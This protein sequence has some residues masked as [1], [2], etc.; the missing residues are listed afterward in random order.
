MT[1]DVLFFRAAFLRHTPQ[2]HALML[3]PAEARRLDQK[4]DERRGVITD[5]MI[6]HHLAGEIA[7]AAPAAVD[8]RASLLPL[9]IDAGGLTAIH[10]LL[11]E[12][13]KRDLWA[14]GQYCPRPGLADEDQRGYVWLP[15][16]QAIDTE[17]LQDLGAALIAA[18]SQP[19]WKIEAR[20]T[21][22]VTRLP[23]ARHTHTG[24]FGDLVMANQLISIDQD[25]AGALDELCRAYRENPS[26][27]LPTLSAPHQPAPHPAVAQ[28]N[29][30]GITITRYNQVHNI[31]DVIQDYGARP[32]KRRG[33]YFCPFHPDVHASLQVYTTNGHRYV[34]CLST[35]SDCPLAAH[36]RNDAFNVY[37]IGEGL[38]P[39]AALPRLNNR[40]QSFTRRHLVGVF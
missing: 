22:A 14:F 17:Q 8:G 9:D 16:D 24:H 19:G 18:A 34:H 12:A 36:G 6:A 28:R 31:E 11:A 20:A 13:H 25:A 30:A 32:A 29:G 4:Y 7:L 33:L 2:R 5:V 37:C 26:A 39:K 15:F 38:D 10:A 3:T 23:M 21:H 35:L 40:E 1:R 27:G